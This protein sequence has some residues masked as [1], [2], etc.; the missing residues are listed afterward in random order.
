MLLKYSSED[1]TSELFCMPE[2]THFMLH[3][4][5]L[6]QQAAG[7]TSPN[8]MVGAVIVRNGS[9]VGEGYHLR[10]GL[11]HAEIGALQ[12]AGDAANDATLY[13]TLEP[14][15]HHGR[16][17]P[18][19]EAI[20]KAGISRVVYAIPDPNPQVIGGGHQRLQQAG[21]EVIRGVCAEEAQERNRFFLHHSTTGL[22]YVIAKYAMSLD[23]KIA[24]H[25]GHSRWITGPA[26]RKRVHMLRHEVDALLVGI[27]TVIADNPR[28]TTRLDYIEPAHPLRVI[29]DSKGRLP[30][31]A[32]VL[33]STMPGKTL[34]ATTQAMPREYEK[35][36][37][38]H[39]PAIEVIRLPTTPDGRCNIS[40]LLE[41]LGKRQI[42]SVLVEGGS[43]VLGTCFDTKLINEVWAFL[44]PVIIGGQ[45]APSPLGGQ[46]IAHMQEALRLTSMTLEYIGE[47]ML[48]RGRIV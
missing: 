14:C 8:P 29:L 21:I 35:S 39:N 12:T 18:C 9:I 3:A 4:L 30:L 46:G 10:A 2:H 17:P 43:T 33:S 7:Y 28:L 5:A 48:L 22:S 23:G 1:T 19:T 42:Q 13:V 25:T 32:Q 41:V 44:A 37:T 47:D 45:H 40:Q 6:A 11:P 38:T 15:N 20:I 24:T 36:L 27:G 34:I 16:T 31:D 26:A